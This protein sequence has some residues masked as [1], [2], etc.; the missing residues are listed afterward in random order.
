MQFADLHPGHLGLQS[1]SL[2]QGAIGSTPPLTSVLEIENGIPTQIVTQIVREDE[3]T[4][5]CHTSVMGE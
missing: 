5:F 1:L 4:Q 2:L 3:P